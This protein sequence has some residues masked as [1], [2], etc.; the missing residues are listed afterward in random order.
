MVSSEK[1]TWL[2]AFSVQ[3]IAP[4]VKVKTSSMVATT[5]VIQAFTSSMLAVA[6]CMPAAKVL[7]L[8]FYALGGLL[9]R[10]CG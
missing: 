9:M 3:L 1:C 7:C 6:S 5:G 2:V 4:S 10:L 8:L